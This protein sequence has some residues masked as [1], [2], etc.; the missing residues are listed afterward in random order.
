VFSYII[1]FPAQ[2]NTF[3]DSTTVIICLDND[4]H[5]NLYIDS[6]FLIFDRYDHSG[7]GVVKEIFYP[8][9]NTIR[10]TIPKGKYYVNII[11]LGSY[12][13]EHFDKI[14]TAKSDREKKLLLKLREAD[15]FT[16]G[17]ASIPEEKIDF[18]NLSIT[19]ATSFMH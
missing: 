17:L 4:P 14:V 3:A 1:G 12:G 6:V 5:H 7:A 18:S 10:V 16:P 9:D 15:L 13:N 2:N 8:V 11:C 19:R